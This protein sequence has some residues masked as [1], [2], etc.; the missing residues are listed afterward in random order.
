[1]TVKREMLDRLYRRLQEAQ[2][3]TQARRE[4][5]S[6]N[7]PEPIFIGKGRARREVTPKDRQLVAYETAEL[8]LD[9]T[10]NDYIRLH[11]GGEPT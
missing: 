6:D 5:L 4:H 9:Y 11:G 7:P 10:I 3:F 1:M 8:M 2:G